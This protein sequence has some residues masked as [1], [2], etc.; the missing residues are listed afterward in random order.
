M[1]FVCSDANIS[2]TR[3]SGRNNTNA[4]AALRVGAISLLHYACKRPRRHST[5][6]RL[7][8]YYGRPI[9]NSVSSVT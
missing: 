3:F 7:L 8:L 1:L 4:V 2:M 9:R 5:V 6:I